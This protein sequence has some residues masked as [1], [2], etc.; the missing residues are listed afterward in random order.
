MKIIKKYN[1]L[2][3]IAI[4]MI[5]SLLN[6]VNASLL[7]DIYN[8]H[9]LKQ[10]MWFTS[11]FLIIF[12]IQKFNINFFFNKSLYI[13]LF[14]I[15][16]LILV[17]FIGKD[18]NGSKAWFSFGFISFQPSEF[19]KLALALYFSY[20][21]YEYNTSNKNSDFLF[22]LKLSILFLIPSFLV[23]IEP[24][25]GA[26]IFFFIIYIVSIFSSKI[27]KKW[28]I[29][30]LICIFILISFFV[31][32]Y[33]FHSKTLINV[34]GTSLFYRIDRLINFSNNY[35]LENALTLIGSSSFFGS[36]L[37]NITLYVPEAP[38]DF[39]FAFNIG[40]F[41]FFGALLVLVSYL[42]IFVILFEK[43]K[44]ANNKLF[45]LILLSL[46]TFQFFYNTFM[47][48]GL[49]PIMGIPLPFLSYGGSSLLIYFIFVGIFIKIT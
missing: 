13:Y 16:L 9:F 30:L 28:I 49:L 42:F 26:I 39:I 6:M 35:Q 24:D 18:I 15:F 48:L 8:D 27:N 44:K 17:L 1:I 33:F 5:F 37:N 41:G 32:L 22:L 19:M 14:G 25:T 45:T 43:L 40:N 12:I 23:F 38:T 31:Y 47:N 3:P 34:L 46:I 11:G 7:D 36:G 29:I 10:L 2:I 4:I 20:Y 21:T